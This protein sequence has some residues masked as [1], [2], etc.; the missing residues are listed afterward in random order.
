VV[1]FCHARKRN[2]GPPREQCPMSIVTRRAE[3]SADWSCL[4]KLP[5]P[6]GAE[7]KSEGSPALAGLVLHP[8]FIY[9]VTQACW[10]RT[11][12]RLLLHPSVTQA[13][14]RYEH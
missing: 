4:T 1:R 10:A 6:L 8:R 2:E 5:G 7:R 12:T 13:I 9:Q 11:L 3:A 14:K